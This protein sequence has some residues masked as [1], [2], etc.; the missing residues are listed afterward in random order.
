VAVGTHHRRSCGAP[1]RANPLRTS[2]RL[3]RSRPL[4]APAMAPS[5]G[6]RRGGGLIAAS[7][8]VRGS[9]RIAANLETDH[10]MCRSQGLEVG[11]GTASTNS[12][13]FCQIRSCTVASARAS[14][15]CS[16]SWRNRRSVYDCP[17]SGPGSERSIPALPASTNRSRQFPT[18]ADEI[19]CRRRP[20]LAT[21][22][23]SARRGPVGC[24]SI[25]TCRD[26]FCCLLTLAPSVAPQSRTLPESMA[27]PT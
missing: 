15:S 7:R 2:R 20:R 12:E 14:F 18:V 26:G 27:H 25:D 21:A 10:A 16:H 13:P 1:R 17:P 11:E 5:A 22:R 24:S 3:P 23:L 9:Q 8:F 6:R 19:P 4:S